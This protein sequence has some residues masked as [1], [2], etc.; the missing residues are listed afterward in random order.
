ML[1]WASSLISSKPAEPPRISGL[2][3]YPIK[4]CGRGIPLDAA[5]YSQTGFQYDRRV[6]SG[7]R[8]RASLAH[9]AAQAMDAGGQQLIEYANSQA[10]SVVRHRGLCSRDKRLNPLA[11]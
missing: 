4:S 6:F 10:A 3:I 11:A 9:A 1:S 2:W 7:P 8:P 5:T